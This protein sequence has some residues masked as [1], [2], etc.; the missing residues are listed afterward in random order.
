MR[1]WWVLFRRE[2]SAFFRSPLAYVVMA[3]YLLLT[4]FNF[5]SGIVAMNRSMSSV[6]LVEA[7][8]NTIYFW[9]PFVLVFPLVTMRLFSEEYKMGTIESLMTAPV[10]D[11]Q[12]VM[13]KYLAAFCFYMILW[14]PSLL[15]FVVFQWITSYTAATAVGAYL[16]AY[17]MLFLIGLFYTAI[18]CLASSLTN[19]Q[20]VAAV[21]GF[22]A[23]CLMFF[24][25]L[26]SMLVLNVSPFLRDI[27]AYFSAIQHMGDFSQGLIDTRPIVFYLTITIFTL[28]LTFQVVQ[29]RRWRS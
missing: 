23:V 3:F 12:I 17:G 1:T 7:F 14:L 11:W 25:G 6:T 24:M 18:G 5:Q 8:F 4:G 15:Y 27:T 16:G 29:F 21:V 26:L 20:I 9:F 2:M 19:N 28:Y 13:S 10:R 22:V